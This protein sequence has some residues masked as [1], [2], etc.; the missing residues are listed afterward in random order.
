MFERA[1]R[2]TS[3]AL[4]IAASCAST[5]SGPVAQIPR[6][7]VAI[8][9]RTDLT[10]S[11]SVPSGVPVHYEIRI[12]NE[13]EIPITLKRVDLDALAGGGFQVESKT[14]IYDLTI[15]PAET[16]SVDFDTTAYIDDPRGF[17]S[18]QPVGLRVVTLFD[19]AQGKLQSVTQQRVGM[20]AGQ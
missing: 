20:G 9:T 11:P 12:T 10:E 5:P 18:R 19:T 7:K 17:E 1:L 14:R 4:L 16:R 8:F 13:A 15:A 3:L 2:A 6:P